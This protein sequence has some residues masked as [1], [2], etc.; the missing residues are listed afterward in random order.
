MPPVRIQDLLLSTIRV[1]AG[2]GNGM[3]TATAP[4]WASETSKT[5]YRG[6]TGMALMVI[7]IGGLAIS[8]WMT[9]KSLTN[10]NASRR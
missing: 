6:K 8:C 5:A 10:D 9:C 4:V 3:N 2:I 7:N 1:V